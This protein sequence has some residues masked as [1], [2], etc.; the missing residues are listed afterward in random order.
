MLVIIIALSIGLSKRKDT[1]AKE[2]IAIEK[3]FADDTAS[4]KDNLGNSEYNTL[5]KEDP[6]QILHISFKGMPEKEAIQPIL[7]AVLIRY[8]MPVSND[9]ILKTGNML[10]VL[11]KE[12]KVGVTE[13]ELLKHIYQ[14]GSGNITLGEQ[15]GLSSVILEQMK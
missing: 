4:A 11:S 12:S 9:N 2:R 5:S 8:R 14:H 1:E 15:G 6:Y 3:S 7:E 13:M 10:I